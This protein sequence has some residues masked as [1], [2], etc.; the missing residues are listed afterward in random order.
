MTVFTP[1]PLPERGPSQPATPF[2]RLF[3][4]VQWF[5]RFSQFYGEY[6]SRAPHERA[7]WLQQKQ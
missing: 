3:S 7:K 6:N 2:E 1:S 5:V 4:L